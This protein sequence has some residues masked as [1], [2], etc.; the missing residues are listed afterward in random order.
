MRIINKLRKR[1]LAMFMALV[2]CLSLVQVTA[3]AEGDVIVG[4]DIVTTEN[5][6]QQENGDSTDPSHIHEY[7]ETVQNPTCLTAGVVTYTCACGDTYEDAGEPAT[8]HTPEV[9]EAVAPTET[10]TGLTEGSR[11]SVCGEILTAQEIIPATGV[12]IPAEVQAFLNAVYAL[13]DVPEEQLLQAVEYAE[14]LYNLLT[15][16][17]K[18]LEEVYLCRYALDTF[19]ETMTLEE[20]EE[21]VN[22]FEDLK[23]AIE[24]AQQSATTITLGA[25]ITGN[26]TIQEGQNITLDLNGHKLYY[27][28]EPNYDYHTI[29]VKGTFTLKDSVG[30][31]GLVREEGDNRI[32]RR[33]KVEKT[34]H[35]ILESGTISGASGTIFGAVWVEGGIF[36]MNGGKISNN[37][38]KDGGGVY[39]N[40]SA[41]KFT[42]ND[43]EI[44]SNQCTNSGGGVCVSG[45]TTTFI[46]NG[47]MISG[48]GAGE[49]GGGIASFF[50]QVVVNGGEIRD[51][52]A[53]KG[54]GGI[55]SWGDILINGGKIFGNGKACTINGK[56]YS[57][58]QFGGGIGTSD[59]PVVTIAGGEISGN[60]ATYGGGLCM[61]EC[62]LGWVH[63]RECDESDTGNIIYMSGGKIINNKA[64]LG[65]G[66]KADRCYVRPVKFYF[67][68][69]EISGNTATKGGGVYVDPGSLL[70]MSSDSCQINNNTATMGGGVY[71]EGV[72]AVKSLVH[73]LFRLYAGHINGNKAEDGGG[74]YVAPN[75]NLDIAPQNATSVEIGSNQATKNGGGVYIAGETING[76]V[77][78]NMVDHDSYPTKD[79][80]TTKQIPQGKKSVAG[81]VQMSGGTISG[82]TANSGGGVYNNGIFTMSAGVISSNQAQ[83]PWSN[84]GGICTVPQFTITG[85]I[86]S[87]NSAIGGGGGISIAGGIQKLLLDENHGQLP[88]ISGD[89]QII[90]NTASNGGGI[91]S[92]STLIL[93]GGLISRNKADEG[94]GVYA[95]AP[96]YIRGVTISENTAAQIGG[97]VCVNGYG[98]PNSIINMSSGS[99]SGNHAKWGGGVIIGDCRVLDLNTWP[100]IVERSTLAVNGNDEAEEPT[101]CLTMTG[102]EIVGNTAEELGGGVL[103]DHCGNGLD[104]LIKPN[105]D[106]YVQWAAGTFLMSG[107]IIRDNQVTNGLG[108]GVYLFSKARLEMSG[109]SVIQNNTAT[110]GGGVASEGGTIILSGGELDNNR[111]VTAGDDIYNGTIG[112]VCGTLNIMDI[113]QKDWQLDGKDGRCTHGITG[114]FV[115]SAARRWNADDELEAAFTTCN[116]DVTSGQALK[117]AHNFVKVNVTANYTYALDGVSQ[118]GSTV[119][120]TVKKAYVRPDGTT[121]GLETGDFRT[122]TLGGTQRTFD[123]TSATA[124]GNAGNISNG[125]LTW[126]ITEGNI[127]N[128]VLNYTLEETTSVVI[129]NFPVT[130]TPTPAPT[131]SPAPGGTTIT[132]EETPLAGSVGLNDTDHFAYVI[133]Y[134]DD[135]VRPLNNITRAEAAT[136][137]FRLMTDEYRQANWS[138]TNSFSDVNAG[139]WYN[140]AVSTCANAGVLK[141]YEDGTF[142]PNAPIT[143]AEFASMAAGFM[144]ESITDDGTGDFSDTANHWA[145]A[146]IR[147]AAKAGW[148]TGNGNKFNPDAKITRAEVMTIVNRMLDRTPDAEH[149]LPTMKK[150][151]DNPE[152]AWYYE[153]VQEATNEHDYERDDLNVETW[154]ELLTER[155]WKALETEWANNGGAST[156]K[157]DT[158]NK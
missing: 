31:G 141:G 113:S 19:R 145:A 155:D 157:A 148:V 149:M 87:N 30:S 138:T 58:A 108:G 27:G 18:A 15:D 112:N 96:L 103:V 5:D 104:K 79:D 67:S 133:G 105:E 80:Y 95:G 119:L 21:T 101:L 17:Q 70:E 50:N 102:G 111:A 82:N 78:F 46:V 13:Y 107:G 106:W 147:R 45:D 139:D 109:S 40:G 122:F 24:N 11:C 146:S 52:A 4:D 128:I 158:E 37:S 16:E 154:T 20:L 32:Q 74:V 129:P 110:N 73:G 125:T 26:I 88:T 135:T 71:V 28:N 22:T 33:V 131:P 132:D 62:S 123:L 77:V 142:R 59:A 51:N 144:D 2:M 23:A 126:G 86:I 92:G 118:S 1:G 12:V 100:S 69:G 8:G 54:G 3:F 83:G 120:S 117:A 114:W 143:R 72:T 134:E 156:P 47:G 150:W 153:A 35:F 66:V 41:A 14:T 44:S 130:F 56:S 25:D 81:T 75:A 53:I 90:D 84:G 49:W 98:N 124:N 97:G 152:D 121:A 36:T 116:T 61:G 10:E 55:F 29:I 89:T 34:G 42:I 39:V 57:V 151:I 6:V 43:G 65:G 68:G 9:L 140:N 115:D 48:N 76:V 91:A 38:G 99:I 93:A 64:E 94:G 7:V 63:P 85:G 137:F 127:Y 136:I 60:E